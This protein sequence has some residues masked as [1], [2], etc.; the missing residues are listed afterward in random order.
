MGRGPWTSSNRFPPAPRRRPEEQDKR[1]SLTT[2]GL[3]L[4]ETKP[5]RREDLRS[6]WPVS[7]GD[8]SL[9]ANALSMNFFGQ[10]IFS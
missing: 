7:P 1:E 8:T 9:E 3:F 10:T 2:P 5:I 4:S 6:G